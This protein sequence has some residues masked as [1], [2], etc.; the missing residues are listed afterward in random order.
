MWKQKV[1]GKVAE[2]MV[3]KVETPPTIAPWGKSLAQARVALVTTAGVHLKEQPIFQVEEGD[4]SYRVIPNDVRQEDLMISHTHYDRT[5]ADQ[6]INCVFPIARLQELAQQGIIGSAASVHYGF[7]GYIP[8]PQKLME[9]VAPEVA[10]FLK[11]DQVDIVV[12]SPG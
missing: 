10:R 1:I 7:M 3:K 12:L 5:D 6:D 2:A 4:S 8:K 9:E 11:E